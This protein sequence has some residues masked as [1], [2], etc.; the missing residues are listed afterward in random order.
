MSLG[1]LSCLPS[2]PQGSRKHG[3]LR[4]GVGQSGDLRREEGVRKLPKLFPDFYIFLSN[5]LTL[6]V[7]NSVHFIRTV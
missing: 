2:L 6:I 5:E 4:G 7:N 1:V 3:Q